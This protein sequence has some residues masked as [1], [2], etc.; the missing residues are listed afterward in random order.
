MTR[1]LGLWSLGATG[2]TPCFLEEQ[3]VNDA[4]LS[5]SRDSIIKSGA[6]RP[7]CLSG[8]QWSPDERLF[9]F[10]CHLDLPATPTSTFMRRMLSRIPGGKS[11]LDPL[12]ESDWVWIRA[13]LAKSTTPPPE[14]A[15]A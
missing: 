14:Y 10:E 1:K 13:G 6:I 12:R 9:S 11:M 2:T 3:L 5:I 8:C 7:T 15:D 4:G